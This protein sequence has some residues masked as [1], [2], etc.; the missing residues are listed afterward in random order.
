MFLAP[1]HPPIIAVATVCLFARYL[2]GLSVLSVEEEPL[3]GAR[4]L[5]RGYGGFTHPVLNATRLSMLLLLDWNQ[6][7]TT[8][9]PPGISHPTSPSRTRKT[10]GRRGRAGQQPVPMHLS[11]CT[12]QLLLKHAGGRQ[13]E[14][15]PEPANPHPTDPSR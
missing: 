11:T 12:P 5:M 13:R 8:H 2:S 9:V 14:P 1:N 4:L 15:K 3:V 6:L 10:A 7:S